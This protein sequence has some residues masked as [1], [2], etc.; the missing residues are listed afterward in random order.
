M[1]LHNYEWGEDD[2]LDK[3]RTEINFKKVI[4]KAKCIGNKSLLRGKK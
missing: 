3:L 2:D 1:G 4:N